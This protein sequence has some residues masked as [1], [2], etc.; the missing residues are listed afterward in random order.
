MNIKELLKFIFAVIFV[1]IFLLSITFIDS[2]KVAVIESLKITAFTIVPSLFVSSTL[3]S[4]IC[5]SRIIEVV[6]E[7]SK[8]NPYCITAFIIGNLGGY[9]IGAKI[10]ADMLKSEK[11]SITEAESAMKYSF[12]PGPAFVLGV[13]SLNLFKSS[14]LGYICFASILISNTILFALDKNKHRAPKASAKIVMSTKETLSSVRGSADAMLT[15]GSTIIFF[16]A[17]KEILYNILPTLKNVPMISVLLEITNILQFGF[18]GSV[19]FAVITALLS[20][21]GICIQM[22]LISLAQGQFS[23]KNFY[24]TRIPQ[25]FIATAVSYMG[26][27]IANRYFPTACVA[28]TYKITQSTSIVPFICVVFMMLIAFTHKERHTR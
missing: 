3:A 25:I 23:F 28:L 17:I 21:G 9:P 18:K 10:I 15:V 7:R 6:F 5:K 16:S 13:V 12:S 27:L 4:V 22:Q 11:M 26:Y 14:L 20:F 19:S 24:K 8:I 2:V 1:I